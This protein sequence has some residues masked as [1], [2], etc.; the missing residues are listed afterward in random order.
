MHYQGDK[1]ATIIT[2]SQIMVMKNPTEMCIVLQ[3][4]QNTKSSM[5]YHCP[6]KFTQHLLATILCEECHCIFHD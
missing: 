5:V 6:T 2:S 1:I 3:K 4:L